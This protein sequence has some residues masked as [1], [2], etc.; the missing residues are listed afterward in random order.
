MR[1]T[2]RAELMRRFKAHADELH[3]RNKVIRERSIRFHSREGDTLVVD[4]TD[5]I[6]Q[7]N[8]QMIANYESQLKLAEGIDD[9][10]AS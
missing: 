8:E 10:D 1:H 6:I 3:E 5:R 9:E 7:E 2:V 4:I